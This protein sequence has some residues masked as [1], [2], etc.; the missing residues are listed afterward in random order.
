TIAA[1]MRIDRADAILLVTHMLT[2]D[3]T[4]THPECVTNASRVLTKQILGEVDVSLEYAWHRYPHAS[5]GRLILVGG[6]AALPG[7]CHTS[8]AGMGGV[9]ELVPVVVRLGHMIDASH[10]PSASVSPMFAG[11]IGLACGDIGSRKDA[12]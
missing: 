6:A 12:A 5:P 9:V 2:G 11:S 8:S 3:N 10:D 1:T 4:V 7:L